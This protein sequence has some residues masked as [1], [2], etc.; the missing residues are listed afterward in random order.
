MPARL[1]A[2]RRALARLGL[3]IVIENPSKGSHFRCRRPGY[4][5]Y[6]IPAH[7]GEQT[8]ISDVYIRA[9]CKCL[10]IVEAELREHL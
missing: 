6:P 4:R 2:I 5:M 3:G 7:N 8:E 1:S 9:L 10:G